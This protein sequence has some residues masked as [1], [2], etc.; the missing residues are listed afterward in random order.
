MYFVLHETSLIC[1]GLLDKGEPVKGR[2]FVP[3]EILE[4]LEPY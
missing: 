4:L 2:G 1:I 3:K